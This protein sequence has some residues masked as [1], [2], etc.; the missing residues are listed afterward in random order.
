MVYTTR[1]WIINPWSP[2]WDNRRHFGTPSDGTPVT[3]NRLLK[4]TKAYDDR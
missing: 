1:K 2:L 4:L 3:A